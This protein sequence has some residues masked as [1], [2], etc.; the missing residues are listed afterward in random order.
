MLLFKARRSLRIIFLT[1][2]LSPSVVFFF[3]SVCLREAN[4]IFKCVCYF[5]SFV[6][7]SVSVYFIC[8]LKF[9][10]K[11]CGFLNHEH[12]TNMTQV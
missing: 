6:F 7:D 4:C 1:P 10:W 5:L 12:V 9:F 3:L 11:K 8:N 2:H